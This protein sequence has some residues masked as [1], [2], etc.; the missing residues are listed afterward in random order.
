MSHSL[1]IS[2]NVTAHQN[3]EAQSVPRS[4]ANNRL[5]SDTRTSLICLMIYILK[6]RAQQLLVWNN[7]PLHI[8]KPP[9]IRQ[10]S[11]TV[12]CSKVKCSDVRWSGAVGNWNGVKPDERIVK[13]SCVKFKWE[14]VKCRQVKW[15]GVK[16]SEG[17]SNGVSNI[18]RR[19]TEHIKLLFLSL[20]VYMVVCFVWFCLI[21]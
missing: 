13:C 3:E 14:E 2:K 15:S 18:I 9:H 12:K 6:Q 11:P 4:W 17:L 8:R 21:V 19:Y 7:A 5:Y 16:C 10:L 1:A 20:Y